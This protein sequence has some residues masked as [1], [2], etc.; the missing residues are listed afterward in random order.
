[1]KDE[2]IKIA[3]KQLKAGGYDA[4]N[5]ASIAEEL[6][7]SRANLH[8]HFKNKEGLAEEATRSYMHENLCFKAMMMEKHSGNFPGYFAEID[9]MIL[10]GIAKTGQIPNCT[11]NQLLNS[12][13][14]PDGLIELSKDF[15]KQNVDNHIKFIRDSQE[16]GTMNTVLDAE[17]LANIAMIFMGGIVQALRASKDPKAYAKKMRG[18]F[19]DFLKPYIL[20]KK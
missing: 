17:R 16:A 18:A 6:N 4:L 7:T 12:D 9:K 8:H 2:I 11:C 1:M 13:D 19:S 5:F 20:E 3:Q 10:G 15:F 14:V